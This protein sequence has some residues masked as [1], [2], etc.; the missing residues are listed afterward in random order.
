M[1]RSAS[2]ARFRSQ[3]VYGEAVEVT[4]GPYSCRPE[5][6]L[7]LP[8]AGPQGI[9]FNQAVVR[10]ALQTCAGLIDR[11]PEP[12]PYYA[13]RA[14]EIVGAYENDAMDLA[15]H[16]DGAGLSLEVRIKVRIRSESD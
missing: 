13:A 2:R 9:P 1:A 11:D 6:R 8:N 4:G 5:S 15:I 12:L 16:A 3:P 7:R 14:P 10:W